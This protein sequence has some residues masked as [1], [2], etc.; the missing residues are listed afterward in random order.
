MR[1]A[2][3]LDKEQQAN[4]QSTAYANENAHTG[5][6]TFGT[7]VKLHE[8]ALAGCG[9]SET[10]QPRDQFT[11]PRGSATHHKEEKQELRKGQLEADRLGSQI[12]NNAPSGGWNGRQNDE[13][14]VQ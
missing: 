8:S 3:C 11:W 1:H 2:Q 4:Y 7:T 13:D 6:P 10:H 12:T 9:G 14:Q 5:L